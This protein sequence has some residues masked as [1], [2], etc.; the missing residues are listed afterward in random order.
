MEWIPVAFGDASQLRQASK[1]M[2]L[3]R[4]HD[5]PK[6]YAVEGL[7]CRDTQEQACALWEVESSLSCWEVPDGG[8]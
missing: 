2:E 4:P 8:Q 1:C 7:G 3:H 5:L 6:R